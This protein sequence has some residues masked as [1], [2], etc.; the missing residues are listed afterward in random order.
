MIGVIRKRKNQQ[1]SDD[2]DDAAEVTTALKRRI[3][4]QNPVVLFNESFQKK[5]S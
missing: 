3:G 1:R 2:S 5:C 4:R